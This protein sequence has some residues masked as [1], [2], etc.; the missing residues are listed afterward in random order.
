MLDIIVK[1][2]ST[3]AE[4]PRQT[5]STDLSSNTPNITATSLGMATMKASREPMISLGPITILPSYATDDTLAAIA[6]E[7]LLKVDMQRHQI[8]SKISQDLS[9]G[10]RA[11]ASAALRD[12]TSRNGNCIHASATGETADLT[13]SPSETEIF[14]HSRRYSNPILQLSD[15][16][17]HVSI[18]IKP[19][20]RSLATVDHGVVELKP[21][22][23]PSL[24]PALSPCGSDDAEED[25][26][27]YFSA[28]GGSEGDE[29]YVTPEDGSVAIEQQSSQPSK[30]RPVQNRRE[31]V[32]EGIAQTP[33]GKDIQQQD[34]IPALSRSHSAANVMEEARL[35]KNNDGSTNETVELD[36]VASSQTFDHL[37]KSR[38][39]EIIV[40]LSTSSPESSANALFKYFQGLAE[41]ARVVALHYLLGYVFAKTLHRPSSIPVYTA[42]LATL[43]E[44]IDLE[45]K[46]SE[47]TER[48]PVSFLSRSLP[49]YL[50]STAE[51]SFL[52]LWGSEHGETI[53]RE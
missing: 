32:E 8:A 48:R 24:S 36:P 23:K 41:A 1:G 37:E 14:R 45:D 5:V 22:P 42:L 12:S 38:L 11:S 39:L 7:T 15:T 50:L 35:G 4:T 18:G 49:S 16:S 44:L 10:T 26:E 6:S 43:K 28:T 51:M 29:G 47:R 13:L 31:G 17:S 9:T 30:R 27:A 3:K 33:E 2:T 25:E 21:W 40:G 46:V 20:V 19:P 53:A 34:G 52:G